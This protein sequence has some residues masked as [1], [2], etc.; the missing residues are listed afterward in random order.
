MRPLQRYAHLFT[1]TA[2]LLLAA[3]PHTLATAP[4][5]CGLVQAGEYWEVP[6]EAATAQFESMVDKSLKAAAK[7]ATTSL[8]GG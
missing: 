5:H 7:D 1:S 8:A 3:P 6:E 4:Y 2:H